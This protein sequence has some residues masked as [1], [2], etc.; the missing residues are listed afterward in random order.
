[1]KQQW[2]RSNYHAKSQPK[3]MADKVGTVSCLLRPVAPL[4][5]PEMVVNLAVMFEVFKRFFGKSK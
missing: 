5:A 2:Q 4:E 3:N 1:M